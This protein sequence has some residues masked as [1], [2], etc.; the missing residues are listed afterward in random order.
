MRQH[1]LEVLQKDV[2]DYAATAHSELR[3]YLPFLWLQ[4]KLAVV[5]S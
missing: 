3:S 1:N 2:V 4:R 5:V